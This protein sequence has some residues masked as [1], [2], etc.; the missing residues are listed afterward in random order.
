MCETES[1]LQ[2][3]SFLPLKNS[4]SLHVASSGQMTTQTVSL[5]ANERSICSNRTVLQTRNNMWAQKFSCLVCASIVSQGGIS[6]A[7]TLKLV[8]CKHGWASGVYRHQWY[9]SHKI[10]WCLKI[11]ALSC[12]STCLQCKGMYS[13]HNVCGFIEGL[14]ASHAGICTVSPY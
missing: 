4:L 10:T 6:W 8:S 13:W 5:R 11:N 9:M 2:G 3:E 12:T 14:C 7:G 1:S